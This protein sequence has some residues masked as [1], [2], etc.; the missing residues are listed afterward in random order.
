MLPAT[1]KNNKHIEDGQHWQEQTFDIKIGEYTARDT[2]QQNSL[3]KVCATMH[4]VNLP[5]DMQYR[6]FSK[7]FTTVRLLDALTV[8]KIDGKSA[9]CYNFFW[10]TAEVCA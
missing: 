3:V 1:W 8:I 5:T 4:H 7:H 2:P 10:E 6:L 9:S